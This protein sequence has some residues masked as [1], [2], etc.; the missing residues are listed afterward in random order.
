MNF[1]WT[2]FY[3]AVSREGCCSTDTGRLGPGWC[4]AAVDSCVFSVLSSPRV[5]AVPG[6]A[7]GPVSL[8]HLQRSDS[9]SGEKCQRWSEVQARA[10]PVRPSV[11]NSEKLEMTQMPNGSEGRRRTKEFQHL[12]CAL[13]CVI[14]MAL[15]SVL[16]MK[17][18]VGGGRWRGGALQKEIKNSG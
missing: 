6:V 10:G 3:Q 1:V 5:R 15:I 13:S 4:R 9:E 2:R 16:W 8:R 7:S 17:N 18:I 14:T 11:S 12:L